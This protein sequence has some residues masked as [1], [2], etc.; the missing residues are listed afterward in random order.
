M[1][2][3]IMGNGEIMDNDSIKEFVKKTLGC[4]CPE[5]VFQNIRCESEIGVGEDIV[6][7]YE[8]NIGNKLLIFVTSVDNADSLTQMIPRLVGVGTSKRDE[9]GFNRFRLVLLSKTPSSIADEVS[10]V[11]NSLGSDEKVH[12]HVIGEHEFPAGYD[13]KQ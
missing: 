1:Y 13:K 2:T 11:F 5:Q 12:L 3:M 10:V 8:I 7:D 6:L 4:T 9:H